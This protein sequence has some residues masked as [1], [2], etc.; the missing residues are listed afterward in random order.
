MATYKV[1]ITKKNER[2]QGI[3]SFCNGSSEAS[4]L[5]FLYLKGAIMELYRASNQWAN[6]P[7]DERFATLQ[8]MYVACKGYYEQSRNSNFTLG[9]C[10][11][12]ANNG[13]VLLQGKTGTQARLTHYAFG[14][15]ATTVGAPANYLRSLPAT[16]AAQNL[17]HG[18]HQE[19]IAESARKGLFHQNGSF[20]C[21]CITSQQYQRI[22]NWEI[23][24]RL[25]PLTEMGWDRPP[26]ATDDVMPSGL[27]ASD[28][29]M[30]AFL[31]DEDHRIDDGT[32]EGLARGF[33]AIN[34]EVGQSAFKL[35]TFCYRYI[36]GNHIVWG[37]E[38]V[39]QLKIIHKGRP[40]RNFNNTMRI[41]LQKYAESSASD[42][43]AKIA[44]A[45][46]I[47]LGAT[48]DEVLDALFSKRS[49]ALSRKDLDASY[50]LAEVDYELDKKGGSAPNTV[51]GMVQ[52]I[53][54]HSQTKDYAD[55]R[56]KLDMAAGKVLEMAF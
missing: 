18:F 45:K 16:L 2:N 29:D 25:L 37:A 31:V 40:A 1:F 51:W 10:S 54:R 13:E 23:I 15:L 53:T 7:A 33:F 3:R 26:A 5:T 22:W 32:D 30:F 36:C 9:N 35:I 20:I 38:N 12:V 34:S 47:E 41:E 42:D 19:G 39:Q 4:V 8:D 52:G 44:S 55:E 17:N 49:L 56:T 48:K 28:H 11:A 14:Q 21:R 50:A 6:R 24:E 46:R 43:E 27:Y